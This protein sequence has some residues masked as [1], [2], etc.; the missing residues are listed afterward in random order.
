MA[1]FRAAWHRAIKDF[2]TEV[3]GVDLISAGGSSGTGEGEGEGGGAV[4]GGAAVAETEGGG[5]GK[6]EIGKEEIIIRCIYDGRMVGDLPGRKASGRR[7]R[8]NVLIVLR[9]CAG[10]EGEG[11]GK[12]ERVDEYY[13]ATLDEGCDVEEYKLVGRGGGGGDKKRGK[14]KGKGRGAEKL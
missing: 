4:R 13:T 11:E 3:L 8:T 10:G 9:V 5:E 7:F 1:K 2:R 6:K 12:I 14:G